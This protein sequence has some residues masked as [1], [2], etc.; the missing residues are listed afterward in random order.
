M[1]FY[2]SQFF[3]FF[4]FWIHF[5]KFI[6]HF[7]LIN[8][9]L[10]LSFLILSSNYLYNPV[11]VTLQTD[12]N[13]NNKR[14]I[15]MLRIYLYCIYESNFLK[16]CPYTRLYTNFFYLMYMLMK[17]VKKHRLWKQKLITSHI[18]I[19][20]GFWGCQRKIVATPFRD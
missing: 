17:S 5:H 10:N 12:I 11:D 20:D 15:L 14:R 19:V 2:V 8:S 18:H 13:Y 9:T 3:F 16:K 7:F 4:V 1:F 6:L